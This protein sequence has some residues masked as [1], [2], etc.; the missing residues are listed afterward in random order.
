MLTGVDDYGIDILSQF[1]LL[2]PDNALSKVIQAFAAHAGIVLDKG[3]DDEEEGKKRPQNPDDDHVSTIL[4]CSPV[5]FVSG[6]CTH[7]SGQDLFPAVRNSILAHRIVA[8][9]YQSEEDHENTIKVA[10]DGLEVA[11]REQ[12]NRAISLTRYGAYS[13]FS[14]LLTVPDIVLCSVV[15]NW[16]S[17]CS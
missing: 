10:E 9:I 3:D 13:Y 6:P 11:E 17:M 8:E 15:S 16:R 14:L 1:V 4:V 7:S 5:S 2:F 12:Q